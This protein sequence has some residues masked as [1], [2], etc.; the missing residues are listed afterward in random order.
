MV[1]EV[2]FEE[3][4]PVGNGNDRQGSQGTAAFYL[5]LHA[6][7]QV[8]HLPGH[9][10]LIDDL[11]SSFE[12]TGMQVEDIS[13]IC[14]ASGRTAQDQGDLSIGDRLFRKVVVDN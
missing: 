12:Q 1:E 3:D 7:W 4:L 14:L 9:F 8:V 6:V 2:S 11:G 5:V 13:R 10:G